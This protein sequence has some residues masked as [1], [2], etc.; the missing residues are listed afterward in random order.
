MAYKHLTIE[1][2]IWIE[3]YY[4]INKIVTEICRKLNRARQTIYNVI[5]WLKNGLSVQEYHKNY[6]E[7]KKRC[8]AKKKSLS[9]E[10]KEYVI[11]KAKLGWTPDV[12]VGRREI[13][14]SVSSRTLYRRFKDD[15]S[16]DINLLPMK[17][18]RKANGYQEIRGR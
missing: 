3:K 16:L 18:N 17:G 5:N 6:K 7:K 1:E 10:E 11:E 9:K 12:I 15:R 8:G 14:L 2:L 4:E 13:N